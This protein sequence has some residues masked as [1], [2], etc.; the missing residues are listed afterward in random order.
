MMEHVIDVVETAWEQHPE[1][2]L[3]QML[4]NCF[5]FANLYY[6][7]DDVLIDEIKKFYKDK[8]WKKRRKQSRKPKESKCSKTSAGKQ[9]LCSHA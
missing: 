7:E 2:R 4:G 3:C 5:D 6:V 9:C 8:K 1:L